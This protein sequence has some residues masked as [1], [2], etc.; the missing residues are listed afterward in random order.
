MNDPTYTEIDPRITGRLDALEDHVKELDIEATQVRG[1][2]ESA[3]G[4]SEKV[5][6]AFGRPMKVSTW[7]Q[8]GAVVSGMVGI[9]VGCWL[10]DPAIAWIVMGSILLG[11]PTIGSALRKRGR[12]A[13]N[14]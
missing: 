3:K 6:K 7:I 14:R 2:A 13:S 12:D 10:V 5:Y 11:I 8:D 4:D 9:A 1:I